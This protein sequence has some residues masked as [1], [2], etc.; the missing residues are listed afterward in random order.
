MHVAAKSSP[1]STQLSPA[2]SGVAPVGEHEGP[3]R[4]VAPGLVQRT[5]RTL[6]TAAS[7]ILSIVGVPWIDP[8]AR[9]CAVE[10]EQMPG[11]RCWSVDPMSDLDRAMAL[12]HPLGGH[13]LEVD[14]PQRRPLSEGRRDQPELPVTRPGHGGTRA[15]M[16][17]GDRR[18]SRVIPVVLDVRLRAL[19]WAT[20]PGHLAV[21]TRPKSAWRVPGG[22]PAPTTGILARQRSAGPMGEAQRQSGCRRRRSR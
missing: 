11:S 7:R 22:W 9:S 21:T 1:V 5:S 19:A 16:H 4:K 12:F 14:C 10:A 18:R 2:M 6:E 17:P 13:V 3:L 20:G 8:R 15:T